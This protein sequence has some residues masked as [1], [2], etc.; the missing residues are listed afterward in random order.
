LDKVLGNKGE[1]IE[2]DKYLANILQKPFKI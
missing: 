2:K 1:K